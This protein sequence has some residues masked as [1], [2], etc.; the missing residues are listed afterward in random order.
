MFPESIK[1]EVPATQMVPNQ[2]TSL[3]RLAQP[4][5]ILKAAI[6]NLANYQVCVCVWGGGEHW[7]SSGAVDHPPPPKHTNGY[8][9]LGWTK[10]LIVV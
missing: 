4:G 5:Q 10:P 1:E 2:Q 8:I 3:Q 7:L 6:L 9:K